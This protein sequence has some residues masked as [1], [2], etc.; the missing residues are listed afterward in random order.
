MPILHGYKPDAGTRVIQ[1]A[2]ENDNH[3]AERNVFKV[4][5]IFITGENQTILFLVLKPGFTRTVKI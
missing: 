4:S 5:D 2:E 3:D 1:F